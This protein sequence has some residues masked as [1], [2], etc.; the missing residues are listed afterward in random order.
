MISDIC[1]VQFCKGNKVSYT[2]NNVEGS[3]GLISRKIFLEVLLIAPVMA[4][5]YIGYIQFT[6]V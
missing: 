1:H 2:N 6:F 5:H 4:R 3:E